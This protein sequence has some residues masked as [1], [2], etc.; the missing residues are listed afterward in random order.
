MY[1]ERDDPHALKMQLAVG[2]RV[3]DL[4][5]QPELVQDVQRNHVHLTC[6]LPFFW[7]TF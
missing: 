4:I 3:A 1:R 7:V 2:S 5:H 6:L